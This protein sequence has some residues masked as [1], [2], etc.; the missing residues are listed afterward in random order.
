MEAGKGESAVGG[1]RGRFRG[2][3]LIR[4]LRRLGHW[5]PGEVDRLA[6]RKR[7]RQPVH[8]LV[9]SGGQGRF[10]GNAAAG[11]RQATQTLQRRMSRAMSS[12]PVS[13]RVAS[14][15]A[16]QTSSGGAPPSVAKAA[17]R[18]SMLSSSISSRRSTSPSV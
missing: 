3:V 1:N 18:V 16:S 7:G 8:F 14:S 17:A 4:Q 10:R 12:S 11:P 2:N 5:A 15:R 6:G 9:R 13:A